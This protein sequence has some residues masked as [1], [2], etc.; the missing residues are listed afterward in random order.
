MW[1]QNRRAKWRKKEALDPISSS[2]IG[3]PGSKAPLYG[4]A[5]C[6]A[7]AAAAAA[8]AGLQAF[9]LRMPPGTAPG[10][11]GIPSHFYTNLGFLMN[12]EKFMSQFGV[13]HPLSPPFPRSGR[14]VVDHRPKS[15]PAALDLFP[16]VDPLG[17]HHLT[18]PPGTFQRLLAIISSNAAKKMEKERLANFGRVPGLPVGGP[19]TPSPPPPSMGRCSASSFDQRSFEAYAKAGIT[20]EPGSEDP[21]CGGELVT[22]PHGISSIAALR[23][24]A[25]QYEL[26]MRLSR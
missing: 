22:D 9:G 6:A 2:G 12:Y 1:F 13:H 4:P 16:V 3:G 11:V 25:R 23:L 7:A 20:D 17:G 14:P 15:P 24:R 18:H 10:P 8:A 5:M 19:C 26:N 21:G